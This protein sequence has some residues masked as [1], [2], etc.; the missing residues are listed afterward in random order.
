MG[1]FKIYANKPSRFFWETDRSP[2]PVCLPFFSIRVL[3]AR[4]EIQIS[5]LSLS[6][7][8]YVCFL[9]RWYCAICLS[10][11]GD[12]VH[13]FAYTCVC[14]ASELKVCPPVYTYVSTFCCSSSRISTFNWELQ[15]S[16]RVGLPS[17]LVSFPVYIM[18]RAQ[19]S[20][21]FKQKRIRHGG[22]TCSWKKSYV[23]SS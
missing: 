12:I 20:F 7:L 1:K 6:I 18:W 19:N 14:T 11:I 16:Y 10:R 17:E 5:M 9:A 2:S 8:T 13:P 3:T 4:K 15:L 23:T 22:L 21:F